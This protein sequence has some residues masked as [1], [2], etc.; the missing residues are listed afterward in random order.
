MGR[1][2]TP[3]RRS[4]ASS[5]RLQRSLS[6]SWRLP[7]PWGDPSLPLVL[8]AR[9]DRSRAT[10]GAA[11]G[12]EEDR[13]RQAR[14]D[15]TGDPLVEAL[16]LGGSHARVQ[17]WRHAQPV[18]GGKAAPGRALSPVEARKLFE[19]IAGRSEPRRRR[20][21]RRVA[22]ARVRGGAPEGGVGRRPAGRPGRRHARSSRQGPP[23]AVRLPNGLR[24]GCGRLFQ[25]RTREGGELIPD[26]VPAHGLA[27]GGHGNG[28]KPASGD[29][30]LAPVSEA[31]ALAAGLRCQRRECV[32]ASGRPVTV[33][34][35]SLSPPTAGGTCFLTQGAPVGDLQGAEPTGA[36]PSL[37]LSESGSGWRW[38]RC[39]TGKR[40]MRSAFSGCVGRILRL[41]RSDSPVA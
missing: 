29:Q 26:A 12:G 1:P 19:A 17:F 14:A 5:E 10:A 2:G 32:E 23:G 22:R 24:A 40:L 37:P 4:P 27:E 38:G 31:A 21:G 39:Q 34:A 25:R 35:A 30:P 6:P 8:V 20:E 7:E 15:R 18:R 11:G 3:N 33:A 28:V 36:P 16:P 9:S 13:S 41:R